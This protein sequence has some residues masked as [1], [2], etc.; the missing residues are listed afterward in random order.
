MVNRKNTNY[1][2]LLIIGTITIIMCVMGLCF[3]LN[4]VIIGN[5]MIKLF[6]KILFIIQ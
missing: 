1:F 3:I 4:E 6:L 5:I 2:L